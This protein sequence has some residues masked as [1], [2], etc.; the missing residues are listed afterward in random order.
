MNWAHRMAM[1]LVLLLGG[2]AL[3]AVKEIQPGQSFEAA[4][5]SL[6]PGDTLVVHAGV[7]ADSGRISIT[8]KGTPEQP[9]VVRGAEG[10]ARPLITRPPGAAVQNTINIEGASYL[11]LRGLEIT[12]NGGD[13]INLN[14]NPSY[15]T[16]EDLEIHDVDVGINYRSDMHHIVA[17]YNHIYDTGV[18][19]GTGEGFYVGCNYGTCVVQ[20]SVI[21]Y[22]WI[23]DTLRASQGDGIEIKNGSHSNIVRNNVIYDTKYPCILLYGTQGQPRNAVSGNVMWRCGDSGIQAAADAVIYNNIILD[24]PGNGFNSQSHQGVDPA[25]LEFV[26]N[27]VVGGSPCLRLYGWDGKTD[28]VLANNAVYCGSDDFKISGL[29]GVAVSGNVVVPAT[30]ALPASGYAPGRSLA[31]DFV[32]AA[33]RNVYPAAD[34]ALIDAGDPAFGVASDFNGTPRDGRPDAG[35]YTWTGPENPGWT[36]GPGF[37]GGGP[38]AAIPSPPENVRVP[39]E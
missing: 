32:D 22:N 27:T 30:G 11:T 24:S 14:S 1:A 7:Y 15:V 16:L 3:A 12:G 37:K 35:A 28:M 26:H 38:E 10:E 34:S 36:P 19:G 31:L 17:R 39:P 18:N 25:N 8:V 23:H 21:E 4:V 5:E 20:D 9:V 6:Q 13:G 29:S 33:G 2:S